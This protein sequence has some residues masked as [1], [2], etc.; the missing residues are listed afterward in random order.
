VHAREALLHHE[1]RRVEHV[2]RV[3]VVVAHQLLDGQAL[4]S[5]GLVAE[6]LGDVL[7]EVEAHLVVLAARVQVHLVAHAPQEVERGDHP[8]HLLCVSRP[9][10]R[11]SLRLRAPG[12]AA[13]IDHHAAW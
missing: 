3:P 1:R 10:C 11:K 4:G 5:L 13:C 2:A 7:L 12:S 6:R 9:W 8:L